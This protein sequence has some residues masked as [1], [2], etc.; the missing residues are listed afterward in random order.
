MYHCYIHD[1]YIYYGLVKYYNLPM[2]QMSRCV[3]RGAMFFLK[4]IG[5]PWRPRFPTTGLVSTIQ[6]SCIY[7]YIY[8]YVYVVNQWLM[9]V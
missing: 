3:F 2:T 5:D 8:I 4:K 7:I 6:P 1:I 9:M